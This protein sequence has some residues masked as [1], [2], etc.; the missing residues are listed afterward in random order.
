MSKFT[1][2]FR[3]GPIEKLGNYSHEK[4]INPPVEPL[5]EKEIPLGHIGKNNSNHKIQRKR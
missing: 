5:G 4:H 3:N 1:K 2:L